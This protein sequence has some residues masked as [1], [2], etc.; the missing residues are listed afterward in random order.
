M[1]ETP[2]VVLFDIGGP[3]YD[4]VWYARALLTALRERAP[5][6]DE[7][8]FWTAYDACRE[9]QQGF[10]RPLIKRFLGLDPAPAELVARVKELWRYPSEALHDDVLPGLEALRGR[11]RLGVLANQPHAVRAALAR[12]SLSEYFDVWAISDEIGFQKPDPRLF[13]AATEL[14]GVEPTQIAYVGNRLDNDI[15]PAHAAGMRVIW[16]LRGESP[17]DP[18]A[19]DLA[20]ADAT[21]RSLRELPSALLHDAAS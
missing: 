19:G 15:R 20:L 3:I 8:A 13:A 18:A 1:R 7:R 4:D 5:D 12:D 9:A 17:N 16:L 14:A 21:I 6:I 2:E 10:Q 11:C